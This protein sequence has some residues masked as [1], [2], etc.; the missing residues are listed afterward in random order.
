MSFANDLSVLQTNA[1]RRKTKG[2]WKTV[3]RRTRIGG[4]QQQGNEKRT[5]GK[6]TGK[7]RTDTQRNKGLKKQNRPRERKIRWEGP[8][9]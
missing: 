4:R 2:T 8:L 7:G 9:K 5:T 6:G 1:K 3:L